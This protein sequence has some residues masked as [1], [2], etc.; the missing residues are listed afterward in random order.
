VPE[1]GLVGELVGLLED[2]ELEE[3]LEEGAVLEEGIKKVPLNKGGIA[4]E[5]SGFLD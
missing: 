5:H 3:A 4:F 1:G 2:E